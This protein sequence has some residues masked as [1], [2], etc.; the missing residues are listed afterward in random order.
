MTVS[1]INEWFERLGAFQI[2]HRFKFLVVILVI[3]VIGL[4]GLPKLHLEDDTETWLTRSEK[5]KEH[6]KLFD[7]LFGNQDVVAVLVEA[8]DVFDP[9]VLDAIE[10]LSTRLENEVPFANE[11]TS[12]TRVSVSIGNDEGM[13]IVN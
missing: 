12:L 8:D 9:R 1:R 6:I 4:A 5:Q 10:R 13:Q 11:V 7:E 3:T 2:A